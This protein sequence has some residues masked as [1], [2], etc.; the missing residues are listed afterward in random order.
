M[1]NPLKKLAG[2]T[3]IYGLTSIV[4]RLLNWFL[5]PVYLGIAKFTTDQYGI[6]TEMYSYVAFLVVFL[7]YGMETAF[8]RY[9]TLKE[10]DPKKVYTTIIYSLFG[11]SF[12]FITMAF[13]FDQSI[14]DMKDFM[15]GHWADVNKASGQS[16]NYGIL[17]QRDLIYDTEPVNGACNIRRFGRLSG[18]HGLSAL[19]LLVRVLTGD[20]EVPLRISRMHNGEVPMDLVAGWGFVPT[21]TYMRYR[22]L[23]DS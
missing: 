12:L 17:D 10:H 14:A 9:S 15:K 6:I 3:A 2:Q 20:Q 11:T 8:F 13:L 18:G 22:A 1:S 5:V 16:F 21:R 7:T 4:G 19:S 23:P